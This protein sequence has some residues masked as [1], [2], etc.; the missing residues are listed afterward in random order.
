MYFLPDFI[1]SFAAEYVAS[2]NNRKNANF[3]NGDYATGSGKLILAKALSEAFAIPDR[4]WRLRRLR[5]QWVLTDVRR[6]FLTSSEELH[7]R[8]TRSGLPVEP[9]TFDDDE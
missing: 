7:W 9:A 6:R 8:T 1:F 5:Q 3:G 2:A 4:R